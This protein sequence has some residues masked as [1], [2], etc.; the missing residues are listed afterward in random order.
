[1]TVFDAGGCRV[2]IPVQINQECCLVQVTASA[3][4]IPCTTNTTTIIAS[5]TNGA[6][7]YQYSIDGV[8]FQSSN[9]FVVSA[10]T[11]TI[12]AK[13]AKG[14]IA[15]TTVTINQIVSDLEASAVAADITCEKT[16]GAVTVNARRGKAPYRYSINGN[17]F[18]NGNVFA[19]LPAGNYS[20]TVMDADGCTVSTSAQLSKTSNSPLL[21]LTD[22]AAVCE[23][24]TIDLTQA[25]ITAGSDP[26]LSFSYW[27]NPAGNQPLDNPGQVSNSGTYFI[28]AI[29]PDGCETI[30]PVN[31]NILNNP[32]LITNDPAGSCSPIDITAPPVT[33]G[34]DPGLQLSYW[35][36]AN[37]TTPLANPD[38]INSSGTYYI[39]ATAGNCYTIKPV[40]VTV[41]TIPTLNIN[42]PAP[43]CAPATT[44]LTASS[45]TAGSDAGLS[46]TY[47]LDAN[48]S[49]PLANPAQVNASGTYFIKATSPDGCSSIAPVNVVVNA[50]P[51]FIVND[52]VT[53]CAP[54]TADLTAPGVTAGSQSGLTFSYWNDEAAT[55]ELV[56]A[57]NIT[58]SGTYYIKA[59]TDK[60]CTDIKPAIV[61]ILPQPKVVAVD[62]AAVCSPT[63]IDLTAPSV[64]TGSDAGLTFSYWT[65][66]ATTQALNNP[67]AINESGTYF[68]RGTAA[69]GCSDVSS[70]K[71]TINPLPNL[72]V[73]NPADVC[74]PNTADLTASSV[75][76]GSDRDVNFTYWKDAAAT[77]AL[78]NPNRIDQSGTYFIQATSSTGCVS[79]KP[80]TVVVN[81]L[82]TITMRAP[83]SICTGLSTNVTIGMS[84]NAPWSF[85][86]NDGSQSYTVSNITS[87]PYQLRVT[88]TQ[89][90]TYTITSVSD[91][92]CTNRNPDNNQVRVNIA[93]PIPGVRLPSVNT[94]A[95]RNTQLQAREIPGYS[96]AWE[97]PVGLSTGNIPDPTFNYNRQVDYQINMVSAAG[98]LTVDSILVRVVNATDP[99][100]SCDF[101]VPNA[102]SP[103]GD[104]R[105]D[106]FF[107]FAINVRE[108]K[109]FRIFNRWGELV[110]ETKSFGEGWN[111]LYKGKPQ[112]SDAYVW[113]AEAVCEDGTLIR[114]SGNVMLLR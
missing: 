31:V 2:E 60:G 82:P 16:T 101:F 71:V 74:T 83:D 12:T 49:Q 9:S 61:T 58:T 89:N 19:N 48:A 78:G 34:S 79:L 76:A 102:F 106:Y 67:N 97:P 51:A 96:Y 104:G 111:G 18:Q 110:Y 43:Q 98:C 15:E 66:A 28:K 85:T 1:V 93:Y 3:T 25:S 68:I 55:S 26:G 91:R 23:P 38:A 46:F 75:T 108:L 42:D 30:A 81:P 29:N 44:D 70:V 92:F 103:N 27:T 94:T 52:P 95:N 14:C 99:D 57:N 77:Q 114:R 41:F 107:P 65:D 11:Y 84:G 6:E 40:N 72:F 90:T 64:T 13:D 54:A 62:P 33:A 4:D 112:N 17:A 113:T 109:F 56:N 59:S 20:I 10:G 69:N 105:N 80:V 22:P 86:Y 73:F 37:A 100:A 35:I 63:T 87:Q 47:W 36:D 24:G 7:P 32:K 39:K 21:V 88:P 5:A 45:I 53:S 50:I 8:Q